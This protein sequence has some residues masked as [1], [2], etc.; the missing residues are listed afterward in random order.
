MWASTRDP[1]A[2]SLGD[3]RP[4]RDRVDNS[5]PEPEPVAELVRHRQSHLYPVVLSDLGAGPGMS[6][7]GADDLAPDRADP[8]P[9]P[10]RAPGPD[11]ERLSLID[12]R[13]GVRLPDQAPGPIACGE[14]EDE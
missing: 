6:A 9:I 3:R 14:P 4:H 13:R 12:L 10:D 11:T 7:G 1:D 8:A 5:E 2:A